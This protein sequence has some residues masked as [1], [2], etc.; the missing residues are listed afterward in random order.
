[1]KLLA[2]LIL[3]FVSAAYCATYFTFKDPECVAYVDLPKFSSEGLLPT[4]EDALKE[5]KITIKDFP[6]KK[7]IRS[8]DLYFDFQLSKEGMVW[9]DCII[10][11]SLLRAQGNFPNKKDKVLYETKNKRQ[12]PRQTFSG[13]ERCILALKDAFIHIPT[14]KKQ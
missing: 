8:G 2:S 6:V 1:M 10:E 13:G 11:L 7:K 12:F 14:C 5:R 9:K 4:L 3:F